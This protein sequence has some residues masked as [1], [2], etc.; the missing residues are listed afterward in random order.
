MLALAASER[1]KEPLPE[2]VSA[3]QMATQEMRLVATT[4]GVGAL[5]LAYHPDGSMVAVDRG[6]GVTGVVLIDATTG[7]VLVEV[8]T[9][10]R[11]G[12]D[13]LAFDATGAALAVAYMGPIDP[14][15]D[16]PGPYDG[17]PAVELF[18]IPS[19]RSTGVL[20]GP[21]GS[22]EGVGFDPD[23]P[24]VAAVR[25]DNDGTTEVVAWTIGS[26]DAPISLGPG[27]AFGFVP[28]T[29]TM[30]VLRKDP[31]QLVV[32]DVTTGDIAKKIEIPDVEFDVLAVDPSGRLVAVSSFRGRQVAVLDLSSG[33]QVEVSENA[34][35]A[36][37]QVQPRWTV[38][39]GRRQ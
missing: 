18:A 15:T 5:S 38:V 4:D 32:V 23:G 13:D 29:S 10:Q 39:G 11:P 37:S 27:T 35:P 34:H 21:A 17:H 24:R 16:E 12:I 8:P 2:S 7:E 36:G 14:A 30:V 3:L 31:R 26:T 20:S 28:G 22:Y 6:Y 19:G 33:E 9:D 1:T 25:R